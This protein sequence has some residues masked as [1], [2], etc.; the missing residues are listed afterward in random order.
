MQFLNQVRN[1]R[2]GRQL[3]QQNVE[4]RTDRSQFSLQIVQ[5]RRLN[6]FT[7]KGFLQLIFFGFLRIQGFNLIFKDADIAQ[8]QHADN[9]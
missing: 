9:Q 4:C 6:A 2:I 8:S 3:F 5:A 1:F 7:R